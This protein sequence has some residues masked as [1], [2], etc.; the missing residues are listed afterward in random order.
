VMPRWIG[1]VGLVL[2]LIFCAAFLGGAVWVAILML[3]PLAALVVLEN[4]YARQMC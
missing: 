4:K 3:V 2:M 1:Y